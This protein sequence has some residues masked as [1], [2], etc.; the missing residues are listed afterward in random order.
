MN[1]SQ[2]YLRDPNDLPQKWVDAWNDRD[3]C[4]LANLF[5]EDA[6]F[7]NVVGLW[8][9][10]RNDIWKAHD[11]GLKVIFNK[12][13]LEL[14]KVTTKEISIDVSIV[15][16]RMK[17]TGQTSYGGVVSPADRMNIFSFVMRK[18]AKGWV[19]VSAHNTDVIPGKETN[20]VNEKGEMSSVDY[21][22]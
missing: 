3:A 17:L 14:R 10:K 6:E 5:I 15:H 16:A 7:I 4:S 8:W 22:K 19:C 12:S 21:R 9:H 18:E 13:N 1:F 2:T 20:I 11:Y